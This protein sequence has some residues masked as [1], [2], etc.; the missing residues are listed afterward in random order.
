MTDA[1]V[2]GAGPAGLMA[3]DRLSAAGRKVRLV[4]AMPSVGRKFLMAGKSGLNLTK[5]ADDPSFLAEYSGHTGH[6][7]P[8][9]G[10]FGP[11]EVRRWVSDLGHEIFVGSTGRVFPV[12]MKASPL[13]RSWLARLRAQ[14]VRIETKM[15]W[16][17]WRDGEFH[18]MGREGPVSMKP[19]V[20][21]LA[22]GGASWPRLGSS[23]GWIGQLEAMGAKYSPFQPSNVGINV[24]WSSHMNRHFGAPLKNV[25]FRCG[26]QLRRGECVITKTGMEGGAIYSLSPALR[27]DKELW[28]DLAPDRSLNNLSA[29]AA[30]PRR[31]MS[32]TNYLRK[33]L[34]LGQAQIALLN[35]FARPLAQGDAL[36]AQIKS[37]KIPYSGLRPLDEAISS[38]GGITWASVDTTLMLKSCPGVFLAGEMLD[39]DAP[40]GGY[41]I[42]ACLA[43]GKWAG[44]QA[45]RWS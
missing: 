14:G 32:Q 41:L 23:A 34:G 13:L 24:N 44:E 31:K 8:I 43:T 35:E 9:V 21:V 37:L 26:E 16:A 28:L 33:A 11:D 7:D 40:T 27:E 18:F 15:N 4:D 19:N 42:T 30:K 3:A 45:A 39:W 38:A 29:K 17:K 12:E 5:E 2:I 36:A 10:R 25:G 22:L 20:A 6:L 1:L